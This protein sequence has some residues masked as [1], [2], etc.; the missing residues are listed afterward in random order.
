[1]LQASNWLGTDRKIA[2]YSMMP[3]GL[4]EMATLGAAAGAQSEPIAISQALRVALLV[5]ILPPLI[6]GSDIHS[7]VTDGINLQSLPLL[8]AGAALVIGWRA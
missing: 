8:Q 5:C 3:G 6:I 4:S 2:F 7:S 1:M